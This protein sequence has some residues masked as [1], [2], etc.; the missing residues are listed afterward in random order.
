M[1]MICRMVATKEERISSGRTAPW[2]STCASAGLLATSS[3]IELTRLPNIEPSAR[4]PTIQPTTA[5]RC[6]CQASDQMPKRGPPCAGPGRVDRWPWPKSRRPSSQK[7]TA[8][9]T[10]AKTSGTSSGH[11]R[12]P[13]AG[14]VSESQLKGVAQRVHSGRSGLEST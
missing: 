3:P 13:A 12:L 11:Q 9:Q 2:A 1:A 5:P 8:M 10:T 14:R 4:K 7:A 6:R